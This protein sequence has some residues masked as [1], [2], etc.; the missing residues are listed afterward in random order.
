M[1]WTTPRTWVAGEAPSAATFNAHIR[2]NFNA[3]GTW[4]TYT[5]TWTANGTN[6]TL[7][8]GSLSGR[9]VLFGKT[10][11]FAIVLTWGSTTTDTGSSQWRFTLP[12]AARAGANVYFP[13]M[14]YD[15]G[16]AQ[17]YSGNAGTDI[18]LSD[19]TKLRL[20]AEASTAG[21][22]PRFVGAGVPFTW[23]ANDKVTVNGTYE[24][25]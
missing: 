10:C 15:S 21:S 11:M 18:T 13:A 20:M 1:A 7:G 16:T 25:A 3:Q 17:P 6:P 4:T 9:Y 23:A 8:N 12:F 5:P 22:V 19:D 14:L 24:V 2:D